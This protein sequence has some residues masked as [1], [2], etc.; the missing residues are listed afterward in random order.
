MMGTNSG[1]FK[2]SRKGFGLIEMAITGVLLVAGLAVTATVIEATARERK[3]VE[4][5]ERAVRVAA[6]LLERAACLPWDRLTPAQA[7]GLV[8]AQTT[9]SLGDATIQLTIEPRLDPPARKRILVEI[10]WPDRPGRLEKP[11]RLATWVH[12]RGGAQP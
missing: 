4:R 11:V 3:A 9:T 12:E 2:R 7:E 5:R 8:N 10:R 1:I 6:N